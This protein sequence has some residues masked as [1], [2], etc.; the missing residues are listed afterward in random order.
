[1]TPVIF[2]P[3]ELRERGF[4]ALVDALGWVNAVRFIQQYE[5][6]SGDYTRERDTF[7]PPWDAQTLVRKARELPAG[8]GGAR[9]T[10]D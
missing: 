1:V 5:R 4:K 2:D 7:L 10:S 3:V 9:D 6:G 8:R